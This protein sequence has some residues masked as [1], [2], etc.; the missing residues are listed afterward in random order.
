MYF[1]LSY[2][3]YVP[4]QII[5]LPEVQEAMP[6]PTAKALCVYISMVSIKNHA[7]RGSHG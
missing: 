6:K 2:N 4:Y 3:R 7:L 5:M 1:A